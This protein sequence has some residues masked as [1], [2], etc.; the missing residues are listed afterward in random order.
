M[1]NRKQNHRGRATQYGLTMIELMIA[2]LLGLLVTGGIIQVFVASKQSYNL[3]E[4]QSRLQENGRLA[5]TFLPREIRMADFNGCGSRARVNTNIRANQTV[6][7]PPSQTSCPPDLD[8]SLFDLNGGVG[9]L[10]NVPSGTLVAGTIVV[11]GTD[12]IDIQFAGT[13][14]GYL[15]GNM[16]AR[17]A[18]IQINGKNTCNLKQGWPY[19]INDCLDADIFRAQ[20]VNKND[21]KESVAHPNSLNID[22]FLSK[23]FQADAEIFTLQSITYFIALNPIGNKSLYRRDNYNGLTEEIVEGVEDMQ[24]VYGEDTDEDGTPNYYVDAATVT[25]MQNVVSVK[26]SLLLRSLA[27]GNITSKPV[28]YTYNGTTYNDGTTPAPLIDRQLR[29]VLTSTVTLRNR[30]P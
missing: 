12:T 20:S 30:L 14:N 21:T 18:N 25:A 8:P 26:V 11:P 6:N 27:D 29:K 5:M 13:C 3:Q 16:D 19:M 10:D 17:N 24:I 2:M 4:G 7:C 23:N 28:T 9:G 1:P 15:V 22:S